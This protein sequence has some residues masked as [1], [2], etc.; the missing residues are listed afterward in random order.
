[1]SLPNSDS[2]SQGSSLLHNDQFIERCEVHYISNPPVFFSQSELLAGKGRITLKSHVD[3]VVNHP[4]GAIIEYPASG[5][6][7]GVAIAHIFEIDPLNFINPKDNIQYSLGGQH[8]GQSQISC[9]LLHNK[10]LSSPVQCKRTR[11]SCKLLNL[12]FLL[13]TQ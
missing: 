10:D 9:R 8:S 1:M 4:L 5:T 12:Y 3:G 7:D 2:N 13:Y 11:Y 6:R